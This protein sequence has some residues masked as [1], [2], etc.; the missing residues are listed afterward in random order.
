MTMRI[1]YDPKLKRPGCAILQA[2][3]GCD[4]AMSSHFDTED[5]LLSPTEHMAV[6]PVTDEQ[7]VK[8]V[9]ITEEAR[10]RVPEERR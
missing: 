10:H 4:P 7:L 5:W 2:A 1:A 9:K 3:F 6:Y 8:L